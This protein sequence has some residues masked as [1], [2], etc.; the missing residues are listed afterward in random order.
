MIRKLVEIALKYYCEPGLGVR[1]SSI[2]LNYVFDGLTFHESYLHQLDFVGLRLGCNRDFSK[3]EGFVFFLNFF[4]KS[5]NPEL[6][7]KLVFTRAKEE[8]VLQT[9]WGKFDCLFFGLEV[10]LIASGHTVHCLGTT[11]FRALL[12]VH[13][14][15]CLFE[16]IFFSFW[17]K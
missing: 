5:W 2:E 12:L 8:K 15:Q 11:P 6:T 10:C 13:F 17:R 16:R 1:E 14:S 4:F 9:F 7:S 3:V